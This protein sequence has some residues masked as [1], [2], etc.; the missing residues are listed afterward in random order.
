MVLNDYQLKKK[1][2][3]EMREN[4]QKLDSLSVKGDDNRVEINFADAK[5]LIVLWL[6]TPYIDELVINAFFENLH[7]LRKAS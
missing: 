5:F 4:L 1:I 7:A 2:V 6:F 3:T